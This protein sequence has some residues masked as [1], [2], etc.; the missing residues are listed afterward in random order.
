M[1]NRNEQ[2]IC[3]ISTPHGS[4]SISVVR[5]SGPE[6]FSICKGLLLKTKNKEIV[7]H[8]AYYDFFYDLN[9]EKIDE[10][11]ATF[12]KRGRSFT[13]E[14]VVEISC[15]GSPFITKKIVN[16]LLEAGCVLAERGEFT[17]RAFMNGRIDL[18][19]AESVLSLVESSSQASAQ[20]AL[21]QLEGKVSTAFLDI[22]SEL[23]WCLAHIEASIDFSTEGL[24]IID[25]DILKNKLENILEKIQ[26]LIRSY[27]A[28]R[29]LKDGIRV[30]LLGKPNAG[31]SSLLNLI[32]QQDKAIV[33]PVAGTTRD[34]I[35]GETFYGGIKY[36]FSDTAGL[37]KTDDV[38]E[39]IGVSR[40]MKEAV[41]AD[42]VCFVLDVTKAS[43][44]LIKE[45]FEEIRPKKYFFIL[46]KIDLVTA[47]DLA[48]LHQEMTAWLPNCKSDHFLVTSVKNENSREAILAKIANL[49]GDSN[50]VNDAI[51]SSARQHESSLYSVQMIEKSLHDLGAGY[52]SEFIALHLKEA[53]VSIQKILGHQYDDQILDRV[54]KEFCLGK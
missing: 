12:F 35:E 29:T 45:L 49:V 2:T 21:R 40:T 24:D 18:V 14:D 6:A 13:G 30:V 19:Q 41:S 43:S 15:H 47:F 25:N 8:R 48:K 17:F 26:R 5:V 50:H 53:L 42:V 7:S 37:R 3:A 28:G 33:T 51:I 22:E 31:K 46:N 39:Q 23:T 27:N 1:R 4:G 44:D 36:S 38:V 9:N 16:T 34:I 52:G 11:L 20:L 32:V 10:I 54:F